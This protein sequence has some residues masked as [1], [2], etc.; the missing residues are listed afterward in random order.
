MMMSSV[1]L[2]PLG[3]VLTDD[4]TPKA[5]TLHVDESDIAKAEESKTVK[6]QRQSLITF[7]DV[8]SQCQMTDHHIDK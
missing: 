2:D 8:S 3:R 4:S 6:D 7:L 5:K 1:R